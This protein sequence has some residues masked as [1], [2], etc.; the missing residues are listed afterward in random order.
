VAL[1]MFFSRIKLGP[2]GLA[3]G[4]VEARGATP[5]TR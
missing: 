3:E 4:S 1:L 2:K 5:G